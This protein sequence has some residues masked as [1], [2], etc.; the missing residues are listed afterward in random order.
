MLQTMPRQVVFPPIVFILVLTAGACVTGKDPDSAFEQVEENPEDDPFYKEIE[1]EGMI[2][3]IVDSDADG[4]PDIWT[5]YEDRAKRRPIRRQA[6]LNRDGNVDVT[7]DYIKG[8]ISKEYVDADFDSRIDWVDS[9]E[10]GERVKSEVDSNYDTKVDRWKF[11]DSGVLLRMEEDI[12]RD[13]RV[14]YWEYYK[15]GVLKKSGRDLDGDGKVDQW[16]AGEAYLR[17]PIV[18]AA[19]IDSK[20]ADPIPAP[21]PQPEPP[22][23][24]PSPQ[25]DQ[26]TPAPNPQPEDPNPTPSPKPDEE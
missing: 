3:A 12:D 6:D 15:Q 25:P 26:A 23:S 4:E 11:Y 7:T 24:A 5:W 10:D 17:D 1:T 21:S 20:P 18:S 2:Q 9:Y 16:G 8:K 14:D 19:R 13:G 22:D